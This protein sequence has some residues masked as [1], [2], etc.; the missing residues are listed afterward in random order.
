M[1]KRSNTQKVE[2]WIGYQGG[3]R[4]IAQAGSAGVWKAKAG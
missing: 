2:V 3:I 1:E 4:A